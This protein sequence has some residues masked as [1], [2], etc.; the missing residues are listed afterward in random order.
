MLSTVSSRTIAVA[1]RHGLAFALGLAFAIAAFLSI[2]AISAPLSTSKFCGT[3]CHEMDTAYKGWG[4]SPH[5]LNTH[6][7]RSECVD[8]HLPPKDQ[9]FR[10]MFEKA[11]TSGKDLWLHYLGP[12]YDLEKVE[13]HVKANMKNQTCLQ[14]HKDLLAAP[15]SKAVYYMH[16]GSLQEPNDP[17]GKCLAC[18]KIHAKKIESRLAEPE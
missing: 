15:S 10:Y 18:H 3:A 7:M 6:G 1:K 4:Q 17:W 14:C 2:N 9:Y 12:K 8:C 16:K 5:N 11:K 13:A